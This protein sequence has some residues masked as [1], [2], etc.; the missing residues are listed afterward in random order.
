MENLKKILNLVFCFCE[1][2]NIINYYKLIIINKKITITH[3]L[4]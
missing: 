4:L 3:N 2:E 1:N